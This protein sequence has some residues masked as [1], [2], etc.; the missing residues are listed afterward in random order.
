MAWSEQ[1]TARRWMAVIVG[2]M[3]L[4]FALIFARLVKL[5]LLDPRSPG[6]KPPDYE[7]SFTLPGLRGRILDRNGSVLA[8]TIA[9]RDIYVDQKDVKLKLLPP[10]RVAELPLELSRLLGVSQEVMIDAFT[11]EHV[12]NGLRRSSIKVCEVADEAILN[13]LRERSARTVAPS[14]RIAGIN[15]RDLRPIRSHPNG[16]RLSHVIG[17]I[18]RDNNGVYGIEQRFDKELRGQDGEVVSVRDNRA[19][20]IRTRRIS[21]TKAEHGHDVVLTID[22]N[23]QYIVEKA[24]SKGIENF[25]ARSGIAIVQ[26]VKTGEILAMA[27]LP[28]FDPAE[29]RAFSKDEWQNIAIARSYEPGSV[30]KPFTIAMALNYGLIT[31]RTPFDV[32]TKRI[33]HYAGKPLRDHAT[34]ILH[35][36]EI[37]VQ[38]SNIGTAMVGLR[39]A[40]PQ[41]KL[42]ITHEYEFLWRALRAMGF[43]EATGVELVGE[44]AGI[45][46]PYRKWSK[47]SPT[48]IPLGQGIAV[49]AIQLINAYATLANGGTRM[50]PTIFKELRT[51]EGE[52]VRENK[53][54]VLGQP[55]SPEVCA[56]VIE[57]MRGVTDPKQHGTARRARLRSYTVAGKTGTAQ[58]PVNGHYNRS[59]YN[60]SFVGIFPASNPELVM[61]VTIER[62]QGGNREGGFVAAPVFAAAAEEIGHYLGLPAD[63]PLPES[64]P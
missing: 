9:G 18:D 2:G 5:H 19:R 49:T 61:L 31:E 1:R 7:T 20:E 17:F 23:I 16:A 32:G 47:L 28:C 59:D 4:F 45:L 56:K 54:E 58:I 48:R 34:G 30:M 6:Y 38:S 29:Y 63:K 22:N 39:M 33:W 52:L 64:A 24:L 21:E 27:T 11:G 50:R 51:H 46:P 37:I 60:A 8:E 44:Q 14:N 43:G 35:A 62:P 10:E 42:G 15:F 26:R 3:V 36:R 55:L 25:Q 57:M 12:I 13:E 41:P 53:P 40:E